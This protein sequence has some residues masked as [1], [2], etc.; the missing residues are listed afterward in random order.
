MLVQKR[1][2][3]AGKPDYRLENV[4]AKINVSVR[5]AEQLLPDCDLKHTYRVI[6]DC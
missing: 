2:V 1:N 6:A 5:K 3:K 4:S